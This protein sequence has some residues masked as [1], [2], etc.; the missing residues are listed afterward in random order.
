MSIENESVKAR[1]MS[2]KQMSWA[3]V[4]QN[5]KVYIKCKGKCKWVIRWNP[6]N[7]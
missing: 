4:K 7:G 6:K 1:D 2:E 5:L 3:R